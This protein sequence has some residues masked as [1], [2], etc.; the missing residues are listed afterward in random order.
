ML[1]WLNEEPLSET[2]RLI[3]AEPR[4]VYT[5]RAG[6]DGLC[7]NCRADKRYNSWFNDLTRKNYA[8]YRCAWRVFASDKSVHNWRR[9][10]KGSKHR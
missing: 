7:V 4:Y 2:K 6:R 5:P 3:L 1:E 10:I 9:K 8:H